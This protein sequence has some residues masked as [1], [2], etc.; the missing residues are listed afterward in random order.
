MCVSHM[1]LAD[2]M[3]A[4]KSGAAPP[5]AE[6]GDIDPT[7]MS[8]QLLV[9]APSVRNSTRRR[10]AGHGER[11]SRACPGTAFTE[12]TATRLSTSAGAGSGCDWRT[13]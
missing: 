12:I 2:T 5:N 6:D 8:G 10:Q 1:R 11:R 13:R 9:A 3:L 4:Q 7:L